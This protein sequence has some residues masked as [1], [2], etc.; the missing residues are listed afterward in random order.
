MRT[1]LIADDSAAKMMMLVPMVE[2]AG[3]ADEI[4]TA[5]TTQEA[6]SVIDNTVIDF[7]FIDYEFPTENGPAVIAY[8]R[9]KQPNAKIAL[10]TSAN[11]E[12][13]KQDAFSAGA[14]EFICTTLPMDEVEQIVTGVLTK[15]KAESGL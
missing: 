15:W 9:G 13:Y 11:S 4:I 8:L 1:F 5:K 14:T 10:Q 7:A 2:H 12:S 3:I 6:K